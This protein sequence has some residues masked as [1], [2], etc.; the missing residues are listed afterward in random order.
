MTL[1]TIELYIGGTAT[2]AGMPVPSKIYDKGIGYGLVL[3]YEATS[4]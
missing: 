2:P 3:E 4:Y 1:Q